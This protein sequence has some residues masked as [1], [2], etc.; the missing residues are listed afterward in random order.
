MYQRSMTKNYVLIVGSRKTKKLTIVQTVFGVNDLS[1]SL[2]K[3]TET[4]AGIIIPNGKIAS[5]Y[6]TAD[7]DVFIDEVKP[8]FKSYKEWLDEFGGVQ[9]KELRD[10]IQGLIITSNVQVL[11]KHLKQ[12]T[13]K[14]QFISD[15]LDKEYIG[16]HH[17][18]NCFQWTG[19]KVVVAFVSENSGQVTGSHLKKLE[20]EILGAGFDFVVKRST[21]SLM[22]EGNE[23]TDIMDELKAIVET[24]RWPE[25]RLVNENE[26]KSPQVPETTE[27][28]VTN[29]DEIVSSLDKAKETASHISNYDERN[30]YVKE[31]VDELLRKLN[32]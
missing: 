17:D 21:S 8:T 3:N 2:D 32:V 14:L 24:T 23:E 13:S 29:L 20:D 1:S 6:Y 30:A 28:L 16:N 11:S 22:S 15:L 9:M 18:D 25:M 31:K 4:H 27:K 10:S 26:A 19:F 5:K 7:I 12:L